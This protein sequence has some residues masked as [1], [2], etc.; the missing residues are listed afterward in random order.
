M[1]DQQ[2][3][4]PFSL[5]DELFAKNYQK[6][7]IVKLLPPRLKVPEKQVFSTLL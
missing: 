1:T 3:N 2:F 5:I 4:D 6:V 7:G